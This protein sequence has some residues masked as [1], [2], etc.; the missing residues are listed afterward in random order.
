MECFDGLVMHGEI[1]GVI[2]DKDA[3]ANGGEGDGGMQNSADHVDIADK[4][5]GDA[6]LEQR[7]FD[8]YYGGIG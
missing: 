2:T 1:D 7:L 8:G 3:C 5:E 6:D 4:N